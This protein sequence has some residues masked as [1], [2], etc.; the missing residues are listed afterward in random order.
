MCICH[1]NCL[2]ADPNEANATGMTPLLAAVERNY[3]P[4]V[5]LL[6]QYNV[7]VD[8]IDFQSGETVLMTA[9]KCNHLKVTMY[10][11]LYI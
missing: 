3:I 10:G 8:C 1:Y 11:T 2:G 5:E 6:L 9:V 4:G 7:E